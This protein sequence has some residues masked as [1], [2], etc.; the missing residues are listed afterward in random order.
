MQ[1]MPAEIVCAPQSS[2]DVDLDQRTGGLSRAFPLRAA[3]L[4][5]R[6]H[7]LFL[8]PLGLWPVCGQP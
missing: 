6:I 7:S 3:F 8:L 4:S 1:P 5:V 2:D